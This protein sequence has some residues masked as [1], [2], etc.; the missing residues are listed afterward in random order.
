VKVN[1]RDLNEDGPMWYRLQPRDAHDVVQGDICLR[2]R[3][4][5]LQVNC[6]EREREKEE[7]GGERERERVMSKCGVNC[8]H[9]MHV[10]LCKA[11]SV[12]AFERSERERSGRARGAEGREE[13]KGE[14]SVGARGEARGE[15]RGESRGYFHLPINHRPPKAMMLP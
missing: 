9:A 7:R 8:N 14:R 6:T 15:V 1:L 5:S 2:I 3:M 10:T 11:I 12:F 4:V 13:Q